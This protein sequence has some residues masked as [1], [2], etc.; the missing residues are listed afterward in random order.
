MIA[1]YGQGIP[2]DIGTGTDSTYWPA[3]AAPIAGSTIT[4]GDAAYP[5]LV[6]A[7]TYS[8]AA[9][10]AGMR[11]FVDTLPGPGPTGV[12]NL[13]QSI[14]LAQPE[15]WCAQPEAPATGCVYADYY[16][17][18]L[19]QHREQMHSD[20]PPTLLREYVQLS[21]TSPNSGVALFNDMLDG[22]TQPIPSY[23][24]VTAPH[25]LGPL[26]VAAKDRPVRILFRN[27][28]PTGAGGD[29]FLPV[30]TSFMGAGRGPA[31]PGMETDPQNPVCGATTPKPAGCYT[32]NRGTL[33]LHGGITPWISD[34]TPHQWIT[35]ASEG[36]YPYPKGVSVK[37]VPDMGNECDA[38]GSGCMTF[39]YTNQQSARLM[40]YHDHAWGIT[41]LN[42]YAGEAAG[43]LITDDMEQSLIG[44]GG[45][46]DGLG[47][48]I[49]LVVQDRTFV[50]DTPQL[51]A[52]DPLWDLNRWGGK[53]SLWLPHVY[54]P[55]QNPDSTE[56]N[57]FGR[58]F[59]GPWF[60]PP[61]N[62]MLRPDPQPVLR[63]QLR[64]EHPMVRAVDDPGHAV[65]LERHGGVPRHADREW[66]RLSD[67]H[68][69]TQGLPVPDSQCRQR[70]VLQ[71]PVVRG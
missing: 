14:P 61:A 34:G 2:I 12:N 32:D 33:H 20:L 7:R 4:P 28:L 8:L 43:Y 6:Q 49:P 51:A 30:D 70:P 10:L 62:P 26:I 37:N 41:R 1:H 27:L 64:P 46:L 39:Y 63:L 19:V 18:A 52:T 55:I 5:L 13:G 59:Y 31:N 45:P 57:G 35:P 29:L 44:A 25:F 67:D 42:V 71:P 47:V 16:E 66:D 53:G 22:A 56:P 60:W 68:A 48:G 58:W 11:K 23:T 9:N 24:G 21:T 17:I 3:A 40:F 15:E 65:S 38:P 36:A 50:P 54:M 69:G